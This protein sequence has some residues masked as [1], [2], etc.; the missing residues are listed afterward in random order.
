M[1]R[2]VSVIRLLVCGGRGYSDRDRLERT[3][4][5]VHRKHSIE[6]VIH[7][8]AAGADTLC[9]EWASSRGV[10]SR[11]IYADW[12]VG[13]AGGPLRNLRLLEE[14][15]PTHGIAFPT[16][17]AEN[18]GTNDMIRQFQAWPYQQAPIWVIL[19]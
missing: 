5:A 6:V 18:K 13:K 11:V 15:R 3:L 9:S 8:G 4:D 2:G 19:P 14:G 12:S 17:G 7:G 1:G 16:R 10:P